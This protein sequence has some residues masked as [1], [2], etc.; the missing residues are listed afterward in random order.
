VSADETTS[1]TAAPITGWRISE[2]VLV[3]YFK[4]TPQEGWAAM[5][6]SF[7]RDRQ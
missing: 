3:T 6:N 5:V 7:P 4:A 1:D 2:S